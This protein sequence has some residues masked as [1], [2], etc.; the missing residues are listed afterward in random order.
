[1][2]PI[3][4]KSPY[5]GI[6]PIAI[7]LLLFIVRFTGAQTIATA[8]SLHKIKP[9]SSAAVTSESKN[10][11]NMIPLPAAAG[12]QAA[13][14]PF[15]P[16]ST[17]V[18]LRLLWAP[19]DGDD[20]AFRAAISAVTGG[21]VDY[22][23]AR[24][25]VPPL[26]LM[27]SYD[28]VFTFS[29]YPYFNAPGLG[30]TLASYVDAGGTV[31]LGAFTTMS[32]WAVTGA[33]AT[34]A[35]SPVYN[36]TNTNS[37]SFSSY[38]VN[39]TG[40]L[41]AG[42][43]SLTGSYHDIVSLQGSGIANG[44]Y[45]DGAILGAYRPDYKVIYLGGTMEPAIDISMTGNWPQLIANAMLLGCQGSCT[46]PSS[47][48]TIASSQ[49]VCTGN[50]A[51]AFTSTANPT[52]YNGTL[53]Y[54]WQ[55]STTNGT[56]G[57]TDI[58]STNSNVY[59]PGT[60]LQTSW[61]KRLSRVTCKADWT[62]AAESNVVQVSVNAYP[63]PTISGAASPCAATTG[64]V[65]TTQ[66]GM[67]G[68]TW[69]VSAGGTITAGAG[70]SSI[71]VTWNTPGAQ[72]VSVSYT[73][74]AGCTA[75]APTVFNVTVNARPAPS[76][77]GPATVC[78]LSTGNVYAT[79]TGMSGYTWSVSAG[80]TITAGA[81]TN[82]ITVTWNSAGAQTVSVNYAN[83]SGCAAASAT[84]YNVT[85][86]AL[87]VPTLAG[88]ASVCINST[89]NVYST[90]AGM[91]NYVWSV[92]AGGT[93]TAGGTSS[94]N[95][96]TVT[97]TTTGAKTVCA[98]YTNA[99][100]CT[101]VAQTCYNVTV[102]PL[103]VPTL[104]GPAT[105]CATTAG[106]TYTT[107]AGMTGYVW[108]VSA[109]GTIT[110]GGTATSNTV[111]VTWN[112]AG[113]QTVCVNYTNGNGCTAVSQTCYN[114]TVNA[115]PVP[116]IAGPASVCINSTGN[117]YTTQ[118]GMTNY[119]WTISGGGNITA[120]GGS[121]SNT[122]TVTWLTA[123]AQTVK[124]NYTNP[125]G[126]MAASQTTYNVTVN[127][128]PVPTVAGPASPCVNSSANIYTTDAGMTGYTWTVSAGGTIT[129]GGATNA[130][131]VTWSTTGAKTVTVS[132]TNANGC[133]AAAPTTY[134][135]TVN[136]LPVPTITGTAVICQGTAGVVY[137]TQAGM[138]NYA[139]TV[140]AGGLVT[141]GGTATSNTI[142]ITWNSAGAQTVSVNYANANGCVAASPS[143]F[144]VTVNPT[145]VPTIGSN[146][147][148]CVGS[149]GNLYY[150]EGAMTNYLWTVPAGGMIVSG[151][152]TSAI[153]V[154]WTGVGAQWVSVIYTNASLCTAM[155][156]TIYNL[157]VNP[158]PNAAGPVTGTA[159]LCAGTNGV[160][161]SCAEILNASSYT[162]TLPAGAV[163]ATGAG[164]RNIT[165]NFGSAAVSGNITVAGTNSCGNGVL[166]PPFAVTVNPLPAA[167]GTISGPASVCAGA[168]GVAYSVPSI[169]GAV[170][171]VW[172]IP[173]GA[174]IT[175]GAS[176]WNIMV[177][178]GS[179]AGTGV[180][181]V[182]GVNTCG[183]GTISANFNVSINA[184]PA[185][186][187][188]TAAGNVL[189]SSA[190]A[191]NRWYYE[192]TAIAGATAQTYTVVS[193][194]GYYSCVVTTNGCS[195]P[196]S[197]K[198]WVV[199]TGQQEL[200]NSNFNVFPV[201]NDGRFTVSTAS[202]A[203]ETFTISVYNQLGARIY[204][205][206]DVMVKGTF[207]RQIDL[208]PVAPGIYTVVF[209]NNEHKVVKKVIVN[210]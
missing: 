44:S 46:N 59:A 21:A 172:T 17:C 141:A 163:I 165:V 104:G 191:G 117:V 150:T 101:A 130:I 94:S 86:N 35:Y 188:V 69:S 111:V 54:K 122:V 132:Y 180:I 129:A 34:A 179:A 57:F 198:V 47:G 159:T 27:Q 195:S 136:P 96:V 120:G 18:N 33:I 78:A 124:V 143:T 32:P 20:P 208:R 175:S 68:Y 207:E 97:W 134:A 105:I 135:V 61:Y 39:G 148:P 151:Q 52:G 177:S 168:T 4:M 75:L 13:G 85:V 28:A 154:T 66:A 83:G 64:N 65:Y 29:D 31:I 162:W 187:V 153:N 9:G 182:L 92:S 16:G 197:N 128:L 76:V 157:F 30:N 19:S 125:A 22:Y 186:P 203:E 102:N 110:V 169:S 142:T 84:I 14:Q 147:T 174:T 81:G 171:Y 173:A 98:N 71:T 7:L 23:D 88:P 193:H 119:T 139:W 112:T 1:M 41:Y 56:T 89:G 100:G 156:P 133:T 206:G 145:P 103:P 138:T 42:V 80:G 108:S 189:T 204:E 106:N 62:G 38:L 3:M 155:T 95:T 11:L 77:T 58:P 99:N 93:I 43:S 184:I 152:G 70:T 26:S 118:A 200:Q 74:A 176:T 113:A 40:P 109:G 192:G 205:L 166:S 146:N 209:F 199:V 53:E 48:G 115:L 178:F 90:Q 79:Q 170:S 63:V 149:T 183:N 127:P 167:A 36:P 116:V 194:T 2:K 107:E 8:V 210:K 82:A 190:S 51:A 12:K 5:R 202:P 6:V 140:S 50:A 123:G 72:T 137:T 181:T 10:Q 185:A 126:C 144:S 55:V 158:M 91:T 25:G 60:P 37:Y 131:T 161:Y 15:L 67:T 121:A 49:S 196:I 24:A 114:V 160:S 164:T 87:P 45:A 73:S 201:P